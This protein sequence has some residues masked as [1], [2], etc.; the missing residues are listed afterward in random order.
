MA[1]YLTR[2]E[3]AKYI[4]DEHGIPCSVQSLTQHAH[5]GTGPVYMRFSNATQYDPQDIDR[6]IEARSSKIHRARDRVPA[7]EQRT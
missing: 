7:R 4:E 6:W 5:A 3:A 1:K 2:A